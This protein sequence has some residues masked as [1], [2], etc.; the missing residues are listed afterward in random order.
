MFRLFKIKEVEINL[1]SINSIKGI[2]ISHKRNIQT[3]ISENKILN[4]L[5]VSTIYKMSEES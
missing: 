2:W 5:V 4:M 1:G 3:N